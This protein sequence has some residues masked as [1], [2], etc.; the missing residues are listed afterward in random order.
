MDKGWKDV[1]KQKCIYLYVM[2]YM[3][4]VYCDT[5][6]EFMEIELLRKKTKN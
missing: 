3:Y 2:I 5:H 4:Y 1:G 6:T